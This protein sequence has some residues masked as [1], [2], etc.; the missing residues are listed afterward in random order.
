[1]AVLCETGGY[2]KSMGSY[3]RYQYA[4]S[5]YIILIMKGSSLKEMAGAV[6]VC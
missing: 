2:T 5:A 1:M 4:C 6:L 3:T